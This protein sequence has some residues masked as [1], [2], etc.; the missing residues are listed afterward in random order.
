MGFLPVG[1]GVQR[2]V[3]SPGGVVVADGPHGGMHSCS[4]L[5]AQLAAACGSPVGR[6][7]HGM[8]VAALPAEPPVGGS[9]WA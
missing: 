4:C 6:R 9:S 5:A 8:Q 3:G 7:R 1:G 2:P